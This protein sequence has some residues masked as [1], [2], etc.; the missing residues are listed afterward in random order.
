[1]KIIVDTKVL[2]GVLYIW[3]SLSDREKIADSFLIELANSPRMKPQYDDEFNAESVR[4]VLSAIANREKLNNPTKKESRFWNNNLWMMEDP[5][6]PDSML[7]PVKRLSVRELQEMIPGDGEKQIVFYPGTTEASFIK[8]DTLYVNF[9]SIMADPFDDTKEPTIEGTP[10]R[11]YL[12]E[13]L[14]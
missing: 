11:E 5:L 14:G 1:M 10:L 6:I 8:G 12:V 3:A 2:E 13:R 4:K 7:G 9:F